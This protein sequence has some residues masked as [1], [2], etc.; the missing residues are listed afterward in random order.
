MGGDR[1]GFLAWGGEEGRHPWRGGI[2]AEV[3]WRRGGEDESDG[4]GPIGGDRGRRRRRR[5]AQTRSRD[6]FW[7]LRQ[8]QDGPSARARRPTVRNG[9]ARARLGRVG[10]ILRKNSF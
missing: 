3:G 5:A 8:G 9:P 4:W 6:R 1:C 7:Q 2:V 10:R